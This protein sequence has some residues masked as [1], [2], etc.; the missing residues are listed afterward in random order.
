MLVKEE[1]CGHAQG[2]DIHPQLTLKRG[3]H[4]TLEIKLDLGRD[5]TELYVAKRVPDGENPL[6]TQCSGWTCD[7][8]LRDYVALR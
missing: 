5:I 1:R 7:K 4:L 8:R 2:R 3:K 6:R